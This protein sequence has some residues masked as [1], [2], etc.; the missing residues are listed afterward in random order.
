MGETTTPQ[1]ADTTQGKHDY[2]VLA[3]KYRPFTFTD[4]IGQ[5]ALITTL[6]NAI[7]ADKLHHAYVLT[8]IRGTGKTT[9]ARIIAMA[10]NCENGP[11]VTWE[12][13]DPQ[14]KAIIQGTHVDVLE[15]DAASH[16]GIDDI[17]DLFEGVAYAPVQGRFKV[18]II[19]EVHMLTMPAFNAL[20]KTLEEPPS[21]VKFIFATTEVHKIPVT[22]LSRCM[23]FDLKRIPVATLQQH[24]A[25]ILKQ[26]GIKA[27]DDALSLI[28]RAA[29]G[30]AR[31]GLSLLDQAIAIAGEAPITTAAVTAMLGMADRTRLYDLLDILFSGDAAKTLEKMAEFYT[32]G[33]DGL[34]LVQELMERVHV[35]TQLKLFPQM[36]DTLPEID[37]T[38]AAPIAKA[39]PLENLARVFQMLLHLATEAKH[40]ERPFEAV[41]MGLVRICHLAALPA[42]ADLLKENPVPQNAALA[43]APATAPVATPDTPQAIPE[44]E[45]PAVPASTNKTS[46]PQ[47][48]E[49]DELMAMFPG[50]EI[51]PVNE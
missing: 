7:K 16:R 25:N 43:S 48:S 30:S 38:R 32:N 15:F 6:T 21:N 36:A 4:V 51:K 37:R 11:A 41:E 34:L 50:A 29:D 28:A 49:Y 8:G 42:V 45:Q 40:A 24:Y 18:Y 33:Q 12:D 39:I 19:D 35:L 17:R 26:E 13:T 27:E 5:E 22:I 3:R 10:L 46:S 23:R 47:S 14:A 20:L 2:L 9:T 44:A 1:P 31:D